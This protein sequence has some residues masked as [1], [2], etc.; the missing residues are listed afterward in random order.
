MRPEEGKKIVTDMVDKWS[1]IYIKQV[2]FK[3]EN[4]NILQ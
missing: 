1:K 4:G 3:Q 2:F